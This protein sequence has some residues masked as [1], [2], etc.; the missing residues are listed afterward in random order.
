M[1][2]IP[3]SKRVNFLERVERLGFHHHTMDGYAYWD[4]S[5][6]YQF[7]G[8]EIETGIVQPGN[9][10]EAICLEFSSSACNYEEMLSSHAIPKHAWGII[11]ESWREREPA[12][13]GRLD[14]AFDVA[15][16]AKLL[17]YNADTPGCLFETAVFQKSWLEDC[18]EAGNLPGAARQ[19]ANL[20]EALVQR[21]GTIEIDNVL[22]LANLSDSLEDRAIVDFVETCAR[23]AG[24]ETFKMTIEDIGLNDQGQFTDAREVLI[25]WMF[26]AYPWEWMFADE[27]GTSP[28]L[29]STRWIEP[30]WKSVLSNKAMLVHL[31]R[32]EEGHPNLLPVCFEDDPNRMEIGGSFVKKPIYSR[33]GANI[34][35]IDNDQIIGRTGG[36]YGGEG[37]IRQGL[38][39]LPQFDG[40]YPV[41]GC[42]LVD[43]TVCGLS[44]RED[45]KL[46]TSDDSRYL[47][48]AIID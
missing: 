29:R 45:R 9:E 41:L 6:F 38:A 46:I 28:A 21:L 7:S 11:A 32:M 18:I 14:F 25:E 24:H 47:P 3:I 30:A 23:Q 19:C 22:H 44:L 35:M 39:H 2:R 26:K 37:F 4:E 8:A 1:Y 43:G 17:E 36:D 42:W 15:G 5:A 20:H 33:E 10:I 16:P 31:W 34:L 13:L 27:F 12:L 48:H 40:N